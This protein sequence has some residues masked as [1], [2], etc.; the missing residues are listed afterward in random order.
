[1]N[2]S[3]VFIT[4]PSLTGTTL[5]S[6][7][8]GSHKL[9]FN[10][11]EPAY[12]F[13]HRWQDL[14]TAWG[15][16][17]QKYA[18][19]AFW[20]NIQAQ[21]FDKFFPAVQEQTGASLIIDSSNEQW[22]KF[23]LPQRKILMETDFLIRDILIWKTP[24]EQAYSYHKRERDV[25][26]WFDNRWLKRIRLFFA[27]V[28]DPLII[29]YRD[30]AT[31]PDQILQIACEYLGVSYDPSIKNFWVE[32]QQCLWGNRKVMEELHRAWET[33]EHP[34][35]GISYDDGWMNLPEDIK[36]KVESKKELNKWLE[37]LEKLSVNA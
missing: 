29:R 4:S 20:A 36:Q 14:D 23:A 13:H 33:G 16:P 21:G 24:L 30:L 5:L 2:K 35:G 25:L 3:A 31:S 32:R 9:A 6:L 12:L 26:E 17:R 37:K 10:C 7:I 15:D 1:M 22:E 28:N 34:R 18:D 11:G 8:L 19:R 27:K